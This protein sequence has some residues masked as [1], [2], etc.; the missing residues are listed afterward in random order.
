MIEVLLQQ[1][2]ALTKPS[3]AVQRIYFPVGLSSEPTRPTRCPVQ[4]EFHLRKSL[5]GNTHESTAIRGPAATV[6]AIQSRDNCLRVYST[7]RCN[8][9]TL[10]LER[11]SYMQAVKSRTVNKSTFGVCPIGRTRFYC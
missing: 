1:P 3:S 4:E 9:N 5:L 8:R 6:A 2:Y 7:V 10:I 11:V